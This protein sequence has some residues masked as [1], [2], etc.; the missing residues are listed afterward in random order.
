MK[1]QNKP[2]QWSGYT[3]DE[4]KSRRI[5]TQFV[6]NT[7]MQKIRQHQ[8]TQHTSDFIQYLSKIIT[9]LTDLIPRIRKLYAVYL[10]IKDLF[11]AK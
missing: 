9:K 10:Q 8:V 4:L 11:A 2:H 1:T 6:L 3:L 5:V 7:E